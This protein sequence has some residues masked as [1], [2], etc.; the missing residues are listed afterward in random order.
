MRKTGLCSGGRSIGVVRELAKLQAGVRVPSAAP[1]F[2]TWNFSSRC[3]VELLLVNLAT[4]ARACRLRQCGELTYEPS[5]DR[6]WQ[7]SYAESAGGSAGA[8]ELWRGAG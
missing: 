3:N 5:G 7:H 8:S 6:G 2:P 1:L 4:A